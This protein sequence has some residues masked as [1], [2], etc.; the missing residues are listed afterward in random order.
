ML[1]ELLVDH[2]KDQN[3]SGLLIFIYH[4]PE[5]QRSTNWF[6]VWGGGGGGDKVLAARLTPSM[7]P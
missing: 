3:G 5:G 2:K 6:D 7:A 4:I 1:A